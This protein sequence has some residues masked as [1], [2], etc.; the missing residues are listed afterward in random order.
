MRAQKIINHQ[1]IDYDSLFYVIRFQIPFVFDTHCK[2][3]HLDVELNNLIQIALKSAEIYCKSHFAQFVVSG[4]EP[5]KKGICA[6]FP[7]ILHPLANPADR[8]K[9]T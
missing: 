8:W 5:I 4:R 7:S 3:F 2:F 9:E 1:K 6:T